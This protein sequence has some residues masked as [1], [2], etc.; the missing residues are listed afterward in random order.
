MSN[1]TINLGTR[2]QGN[3]RFLEIQSVN[4]DNFDFD[5]NSQL[6]LADS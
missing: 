1:R 3:E 5:A 6:N 2:L 4:S